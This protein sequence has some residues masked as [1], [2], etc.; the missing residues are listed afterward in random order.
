MSDL[1]REVKELHSRQEPHHQR[2]QARK[3][4]LSPDPSSAR[5]PKARTNLEPMNHKYKK[6]FRVSNGSYYGFL[7]FILAGI[8]HAKCNKV[9]WQVI[10]LDLCTAFS[11]S[12]NYLV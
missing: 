3:Y 12:F 11:F 9:F 8:V 10:V 4:S 7:S 6:D 2:N 5:Y 1:I